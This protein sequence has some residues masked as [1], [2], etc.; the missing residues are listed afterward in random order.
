MYVVKILDI[1]SRIKYD[2][3]NQKLAIIT[4]HLSVN[5]N[6][7]WKMAYVKEFQDFTENCSFYRMAKKSMA[8]YPEKKRFCTQDFIG[9]TV[10]MRL[11]VYKKRNG[12]EYLHILY[13]KPFNNTDENTEENNNE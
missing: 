5:V 7:E 9:E 10:Q 3:N 11:T 1:E 8:Y 2:T 4:Y 13:F 6:N 12:D